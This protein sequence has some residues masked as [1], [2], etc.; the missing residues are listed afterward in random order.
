M[1]L[2]PLQ[3]EKV[4]SYLE[5]KLTSGDSQVMLALK[6]G[7]SIRFEE[8]KTRPMG[9]TASGVRGITLLMKMTRLLVWLL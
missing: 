5:A 2:M 4:M 9:R 1:E 7:K 8:A 3:L 6:S